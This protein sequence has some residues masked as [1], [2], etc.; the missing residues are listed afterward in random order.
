LQQHSGPRPQP[1]P[2]T[3][4][5]A[6]A[7]HAGLQKAKVHHPDA[8]AGQTPVRGEREPSRAQW[9]QVLTAYQVLG[10]ARSRSLYDLSLAAGASP[11][12][13]QAAAAGVGQG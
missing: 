4:P 5:P 1:L 7:A 9:I 11:L 6:P 8:D 12:L 2:T 3:V 10:C 13:R